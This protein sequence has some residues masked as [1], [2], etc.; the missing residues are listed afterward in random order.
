MQLFDTHA[1]LNDERLY[2]RLDEVLANAR[3]ASLVGIATVGYDWQSS[4]FAVRLAE[5]HPGYLY[6]VTGVHPHDASTWSSQLADKL[7]QLALEPQ[8]VAV[9]E[10]GL[11]YYRDLSPRDVQKKV[12]CEQI[13]LAKTLKKPIVI[14]DRDAHG[15]ILKILKE[16]RAGENGGILH[17]FSGSREMAL[18]CLRLGFHLSFAG[19]LTYTNARNLTEACAAVPLSEMLVETDCPYL[20]PHPL[21]GKINEPAN[22]ALVAEKIAQIK[23]ISAEEVG[24][25]TTANARAVYRI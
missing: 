21:R 4:L 9:G 10:I 18:D 17:C 20:S 16:Q 12:F 19:P 3:A 5:K 23:G 11:D 13:E 2:N 7:Y 8:V 14:H 15:D 24:R 25:I 1:H 22:C 6:A